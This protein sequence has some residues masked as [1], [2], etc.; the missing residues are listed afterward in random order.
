MRGAL[1]DLSPPLPLSDCQ[2]YHL[3]VLKVGAGAQRELVDTVGARDY[4]T[5]VGVTMLLE[6]AGLA[7]ATASWLHPRSY[8]WPG[9]LAMLVIYAAPMLWLYS[10]ALRDQLRTAEAPPVPV[11]ARA[12]AWAVWPAVGLSAL[13]LAILGVA[14][15]QVMPNFLGFVV[16]QWMVFGAILLRGA[17]LVANRQ[18]AQDL[19]ILVDVT[20]FPA[21]RT[22]LIGRR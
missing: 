7:I 5:A 11:R 9:T 16:V 20:H 19:R 13:F 6:A 22:L 12:L 10:R 14:I 2:R 18:R 17:G 15:A 8:Y 21:G 1:G 4:F 3:R